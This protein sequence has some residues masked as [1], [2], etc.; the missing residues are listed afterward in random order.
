MNIIYL[1]IDGVLNCSDEHQS[2]SHDP[3]ENF[4]AP[5]VRNLNRLCLEGDASIVI[6]SSWRVLI[7]DVVSWNEIF[8]AWAKKLNEYNFMSV[9]DITGRSSNGFRGREVYENFSVLN[10]YF[11]E[12]INYVCIDDD[13]D[14]YDN[15]PLIR[16]D[17]QYGLTHECVDDAIRCLKSGWIGYQGE[18]M[19]ENNPPAT[20]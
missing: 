10:E 13:T 7:P 8:E 11:G 14:F 19:V 5:L 12:K 9:I 18:R 6:S 16:T 20:G 15:Q 1:D 17:P 3:L 4:R 2:M